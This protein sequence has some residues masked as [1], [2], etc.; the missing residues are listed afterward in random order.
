MP[1][2]QHRYLIALDNLDDVHEVAITPADQLRAETEGNRKG[3]VEPKR[4]GTLVTLLWLWAA[5]RR[6]GIVGKDE[7]FEPFVERLAAWDAVKDEAGDPVVDEVDPTQEAESSTSASS[8]QP[9]SPA[10][11]G[12]GPSSPILP[13]SPLP[14]DSSPRLTPS[15]DPVP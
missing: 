10:S 8:S 6:T 7:K 4:Q 5:S 14:S 2:T 1:L 9:A 11:T 3:L 12:S 13:S 15:E